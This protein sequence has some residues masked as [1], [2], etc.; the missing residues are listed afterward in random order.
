MNTCVEFQSTQGYFGLALVNGRLQ[1]A[2]VKSFFE[3]NSA[4]VG[5]NLADGR[6]HR[7]MVN[8]T[9][10]DVLIGVDSNQ[11]RLAPP[12]GSQPITDLKDT[13]YMG[14]LSN[15]FSNLGIVLSNQFGT[16]S[17]CARRVTINGQMITFETAQKSG[18]FPEP[19]PGCKKDE[20][21]VTSSCANEGTCDATWTGFE[22]SC[23]SDFVG[24]R[25]EN[26]EL[27]TQIT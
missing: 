3:R 11:T 16:F 15:Q 18:N 9:S 13:L 22:C 20:N 2:Y 26:G 14:A 23:L 5:Q 27:L 25:C 24:E 17:G 8:V 1:A 19:S 10:G 4:V 7:V 12:R 6:W 21:C